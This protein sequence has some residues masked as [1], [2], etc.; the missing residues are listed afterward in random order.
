MRGGLLAF[1][2]TGFAGLNLG[3]DHLH[4]G[5]VVFIVVFLRLPFAGHAIDELLGQLDFLL[6]N[7]VFFRLA[8]RDIE[9]VRLADFMRY[10]NRSSINAPLRATTAARY[11][12]VRST[13]RTI[14]ALRADSMASR[15]ST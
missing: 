8:V 12:R 15:S 9:I 2:D 1:R 14:P 5:I 4:Q 6:R 13:T 7:L 10:R 3:F 11:C